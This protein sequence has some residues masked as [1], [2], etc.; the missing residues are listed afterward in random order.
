[1]KKSLSRPI[2]ASPGD[3]YLYYYW[4]PYL[5]QTHVDKRLSQELLERGK[6]LK[7]RYTQQLAGAIKNEFSYPDTSFFL[8][9]FKKYVELYLVGYRRYTGK[10]QFNPPFQMKELWINFQRQHEYNPVHIHMNCTHSFVLYLKV[11]KILKKE[12]ARNNT[13]H[14][15]PG[16]ITFFYGEPNDWAISQHNFFPEEN[17]LFIFPS[18][19]R[20]EVPAFKSNVTRISVA[21]NFTL[22]I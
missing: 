22:Q 18:N 14:P 13:R 12:F 21:G 20:H 10:S 7:T 5:F 1:M 9:Y 2:D 15:G 4:G 6:K 19:V 11:P 3:D 8:S 17:M 16:S